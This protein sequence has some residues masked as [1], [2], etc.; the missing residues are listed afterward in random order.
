MILL[1][2]VPGLAACEGEFL[3]NMQQMISLA[4]SCGEYAGNL[5][6]LGTPSGAIS[7]DELQYSCSVGDASSGVSSQLDAFNECSRVYV[8]AIAAY[9]HAILVA[10]NYGGDC[11]AAANEGLSVYPVQ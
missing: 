7:P 3:P 8:C 5:A 9:N 10:D 2:S 6:S 1:S 4:E 11:V